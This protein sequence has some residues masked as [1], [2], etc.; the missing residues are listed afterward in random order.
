MRGVQGARS[1]ALIRLGAVALA[2]IVVV[3]VL[4]V[5]S[6]GGSS[7]DGGPAKPGLF[8]GIPQQGL[9]LGKPDAPVTLVEYADLQCP[10]C[11]QYDRDVLPTLVKRYVRPGKLRLELRPLAFIGPDSVRMARVVEAAAEQ[12]RAWP[13]VDL[14][15]HNQG[16]ENSGYATDAYMRKLMARVPG[17]DGDGALSEAGS[18]AVT[19]R[20]RSAQASAG[21]A[22][23][24][25]TPSF[26]VG[27]TGGRL[28]T[29]RPSALEPGPF[30][31]AIDKQLR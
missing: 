28:A 31:D 14:I 9:A 4:V 18:R 2:A 21:R 17:L 29:L 5:V 6:Q 8:T 13:L 22:G 15:Y 27:R 25:S 16:R 1:P 20:L 7:D 26:L 11:A 10:F 3:V 12:D 19:A 23:I 24:D 30:T